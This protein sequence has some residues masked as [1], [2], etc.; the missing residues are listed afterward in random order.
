[1][2]TFLHTAD[3]QIG[4]QFSSFDPEHAP[5]LAEARLAAVERLAALAAAHRVDAVL[6]AGDVFD[7]QTVSDR[8]VRRLFNALA[9]YPGPWLMIPGNHDAALAESVWTRAQRLGAVPA[10]AHLLLSAEPRLF[11][12]LGFAVLPAPLTQRHTHGDLSAWFD[13]CDTPAGL[14][15]LGLAHGSVQGL[16][17]DE[18]DA[19]N[20]IAPDRAARAR[21][22][23]LALGDWHGCK[24][25]DARTWYAGTPEPD[26][27]KD[28][29]AGQALLVSLAAP[30]AEPQVQ[31][32][33]VG[34][35]RWQALEASLQVASDVQAL[36]E[37]LDAL[38]AHDVASLR[39]AGS[40][41][42]AGHA[43]LLAAIA[44]AEAA[45]R[46]L[47]C[48]LAD[49]RLNPTGDD[50]ASLQADGYLG[51]LIA[52]LRTE[53][54]GTTPEARTARD[55]LALLTAALAPRNLAAVAPPLASTPPA[56]S[57]LAA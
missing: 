50:I 56:A 13:A 12:E 19:T 48:D 41:D 25:I 54:A 9:A 35:Y 30:G 16:L 7:A 31:A 26:R 32:L 51:E 42:L 18:I 47:Q 45:A 46:D 11:A 55:A 4:R 28:N 20:P 22:D 14:L 5:L 52:E 36:V 27:F 29:G 17:A 37:R 21:L 10:N 49:L 53:Q 34:Q 23:Y 57:G 40:T 38:G 6:V 1:M 39:V 43:A 8:I 15:R 33:A 24:R 3:W 2:P 44:R